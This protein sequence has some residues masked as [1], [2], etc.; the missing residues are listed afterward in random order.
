MTFDD[1]I[2]EQNFGFDA[3]SLKQAVKLVESVLHVPFVFRESSFYGEYA[4]SKSAGCELRVF[5]NQVEGN[6]NDFLEPDL[7]EWPFVIRVTSFGQKINLSL[8]REFFAV[9]KS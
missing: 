6:K 3:A 8:S 7:R 4:L 2:F 1:E 9:T 5:S